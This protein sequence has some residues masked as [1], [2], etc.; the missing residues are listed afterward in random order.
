MLSDVLSHLRL[1]L[2]P[3]IALVVFLLVFAGIVIKTLFS[4]KSEMQEAARVPLD[5]DEPTAP[6]S[7][8]T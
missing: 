4:P 2:F 8:G 6:I 3:T 1:D 7:E 5:D